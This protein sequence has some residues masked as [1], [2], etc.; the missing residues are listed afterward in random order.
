VQ[1]T[2]ISRPLKVKYSAFTH[3]FETYRTSLSTLVAPLAPEAI[4][5]RRTLQRSE[6]GR[7]VC[8]EALCGTLTETSW[9]KICRTFGPCP[10][11]VNRRSEWIGDAW[12]QSL[13]KGAPCAAI[14]PHPRLLA[15]GSPQHSMRRSPSKSAALDATLALCASVRR[16][17]T[18]SAQWP[19]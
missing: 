10:H 5:A 17:S 18:Q 2:V 8:Q 13:T 4:L 15:S 16:S 9:R 14:R 3:I 11:A 12:K 19:S 1:A 7:V 6:H